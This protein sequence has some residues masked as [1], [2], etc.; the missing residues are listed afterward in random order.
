MV[1]SWLASVLY[2]GLEQLGGSPAI[3]LLV[4]AFSAGLAGI[5]WALTR[6][7]V[8][9]L[10]RMFI[11]F[12]ALG[13]A[14]LGWS[15][16]P[17]MFGLVGLGLVLLALT[18][19]FTPWML[20]PVFWIWANTHGSFPLGLVVI[21]AVLVGAHLD[22]DPTERERRVLLW[23]VV[24]TLSAVIGPLGIDALV[25]PVEM[26]GKTDLLGRI[27]EW[28]SP[29]FTDIPTRL[30]LLQVV[31]A[32][33]AL[34]RRPTYRAAIPLVVFVAASLLASRNITVA[35]LVL[36]PGMAYGL[37]GL[38]ALKGERR[39]PVAFA[40]SGVMATLVVVLVAVSSSGGGWVFDFYP[41]AALA[42]AQS[43]GALDGHL[44]STDYVGNFLEGVR[45]EGAGVFIDDRYDMYP[46]EVIEDYGTVA[47][48]RAGWQEVLDRREVSTVIWT[49]DAP[50]S[51]FL[52]ADPEWR[53]EWQDGSWIVAVRR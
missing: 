31:V 12:L 36:I 34:T 33:L 38:G 10:P 9:L 1:Q 40:L 27:I 32:I 30:Y 2:A 41:R 5:V 4:V 49:A 15:E 24:G 16:R 6:P 37:S 26:V 7:A 50:L 51:Q 45:G 39:S 20:V 52:A 17:L 18:G 13:V 29:T 23:S 42:H 35:S 11:A 28:Q 44:L 21:G 19:R 53:M 25:F 14:A 46:R 48:G 47:D 8:S 22:G 43:T 3:H